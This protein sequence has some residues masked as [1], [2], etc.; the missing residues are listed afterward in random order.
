[1]TQ[2]SSDLDVATLA[3]TKGAQVAQ[4]HFRNV[5]ATNKAGPGAY[6]P[7]T[8]GDKDAELKVREVLKAHR[9]ADAVFGEEFGRSKSTNGREWIIDPIDG[10]R[11]FVAG[12]PTWGTLVGLTHDDCYSVG[13]ACQ[14]MTGDVFSGDSE[15]AWLNGNVMKTRSAT[16]Q[17]DL[18]IATT[19]ID[20]LAPPYRAPFEYLA[21]KVAITRYG[22]DWYSYALL[23]AG[24][25]D[26]VI[27]CGLQ[28]YDIAA[29]VPIVRGAGGI[30]TDLQGGSDIGPTVLACSNT[31][32]HAQMLEHF[33]L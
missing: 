21:S 5:A 18:H 15:T 31:A 19:A 2:I 9:P 27:E 4:S 24:G 8:Q 33:A 29:L 13:A 16:T 10:T 20:L 1:M 26:A 32:V 7:V 22:L 23:A 25:F 14:P 12:V 30:V 28:P 17:A 6:D 11:A 3:C